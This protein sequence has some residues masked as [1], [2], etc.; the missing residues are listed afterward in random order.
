MEW[1]S[2][3]HSLALKKFES[4]KI[5]CSMSMSIII[6]CINSNDWK[7]SIKWI[8]DVFLYSLKNKWRTYKKAFIF[9]K[10]KER[11]VGMNT[12]IYKNINN[13]KKLTNWQYQTEWTNSLKSYLISLDY[14]ASNLLVDQ[15]LCWPKY[16]NA[17]IFGN[18]FSN[19]WNSWINSWILWTS[20]SNA[21]TDDANQNWSSISAFI[22]HRATW[23]A[24]EISW[25]YCINTALF[26]VFLFV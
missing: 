7:T 2:K 25:N 4:M 21:P 1:K 20:A 13:Y 5:T 3:H 11:P 14:D 12:E 18:P 10:I 6:I 15:V 24:C 16:L 9:T 22:N 19:G 23:V 26:S 8:N 17:S